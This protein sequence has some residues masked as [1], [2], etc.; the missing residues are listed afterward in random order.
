[1]AEPRCTRGCLPG[2]GSAP[3]ASIGGRQGR[4]DGRARVVNGA[5]R[6][7]GVLATPPAQR[8][9]AAQ[10][11]LGRPGGTHRRGRPELPSLS[12]PGAVCNGLRVY[13]HARSL[14]LDGNSTRLALDRKGPPRSQFPF[15]CR[16]RRAWLRACP[17]VRRGSRGRWR[18]LSLTTKGFDQKRATVG[19]QCSH[20]DTLPSIPLPAVLVKLPDLCCNTQ[21][22]LPCKKVL[23]GYSF[24][25]ADGP[26]GCT[27]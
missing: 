2:S 1:M 23:A 4:A 14:L 16:A 19:P 10:R 12:C 8:Q 25:R 7:E 17:N 24:L 26:P 15:F 27:P 6:R 21:R 13:I 22:Y 3:Q 9:C 5:A 11:H 18:S 20:N